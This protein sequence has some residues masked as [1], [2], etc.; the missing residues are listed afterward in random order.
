MLTM[1]N[2]GCPSPLLAGEGSPVGD[3]PIWAGLSA[4]TGPVGLLAASGPSSAHGPG[5]RDAPALALS[6]PVGVDAAG[7]L[8]GWVGRWW[9]AVAAA[10]RK[11]V[12]RLSRPTAG[13]RRWLCKVVAMFVVV[14]GR[15]VY[16]V[17][18]WRMRAADQRGSQITD[19]LGLVVIGIVAIVA[20]GGLISGLDQAVFKWI[21]NQLGLSGSGGAA[22]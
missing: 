3:A 17:P 16:L 4:A 8:R 2:A 21:T 18:A 14:L 5:L 11:P 9:L 20:I 22:G 10:V 7:A 15:A 1:D 6:A 13:C 19:N 12:L